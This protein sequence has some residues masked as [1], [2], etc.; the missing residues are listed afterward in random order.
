MIFCTTLQFSLS[1]CVEEY[2]IHRKLG[3]TFTWIFNYTT[4]GSHIRDFRARCKGTFKVRAE[5]TDARFLV[6]SESV[7]YV[8]YFL[9]PFL[10]SLA[11]LDQLESILRRESIR[12]LETIV[13][14]APMFSFS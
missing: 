13:S 14:E 10:Q 3:F 11:A 5:E 6:F 9:G 12:L 8:T 4:G 1:K 7:T 2:I